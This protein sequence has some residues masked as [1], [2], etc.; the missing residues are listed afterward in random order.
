MTDELSDTD[1]PYELLG[2][3]RDA[4]ERALRKA[5]VRLIKRFRPETDPDSFKRIHAAYERAKS[6]YFPIL[7][8][9]EAPA[10]PAEP[11]PDLPA[12]GEP[13]PTPA[14]RVREAES[15]DGLN[16]ARQTLEDLIGQ[17]ATDSELW[18]EGARICALQGEEHVIAW[19]ARALKE[20]APV[21]GEFLYDV[22]THIAASVL[23]R[24]DITLGVLAGQD[25]EYLRSA[26]EREWV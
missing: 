7:H 3:A 1:D 11:T 9:L 15:E 6:G 10:S 5:Y 21:G 2:V 17:H 23:A 13:V 14:E 16:A 18:L 12:S 26:L 4:D 24:D 19:W 8:A 22:P 20:G 25:D